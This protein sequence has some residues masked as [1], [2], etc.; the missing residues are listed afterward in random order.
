MILWMAILDSLASS[1]SDPKLRIHSN[2][3]KGFKTRNKFEFVKKLFVDSDKL[4]VSNRTKAFTLLEMVIALGIIV[5]FS[6]M[7]IGYSRDTG[8]RLAL[9]GKQSEFINLIGHAKSLSQNFVIDPPTGKQVCSYGVHWDGGRKF[10][11]FQ[12]LVSTTDPCDTSDPSVNVFTGDFDTS[13]ERLKG[14]LNNIELDS[15]LEVGAAT[16]LA[17]VVFIPPDP[18]VLI[19][20]DAITE[21]SAS[22]ASIIIK[23]RESSSHRF[24]VRINKYGQITTE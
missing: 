14:D 22:T 13:D 15:T 5:F 6:G 12:D 20:W 17:N 1:G 7:L 8:R 21:T 11:V 24:E 3:R 10:A 18:S 2:L 16:D 4:V 23:L 9:I 19:N